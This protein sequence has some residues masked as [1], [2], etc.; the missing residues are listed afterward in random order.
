MT[1]TRQVKKKD[2]QPEC[3]RSYKHITVANSPYYK[4]TSFAAMRPIIETKDLK[5]EQ[6]T[7]S[8]SSP[9]VKDHVE[10]NNNH[11]GFYSKYKRMSSSTIIISQ[12]TCTFSKSALSTPSE[13]PSILSNLSIS[14]TELR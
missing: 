7:W 2:L 6:H 4:G 13:N 1:N 10:M 11:S 8:K 14:S 5:Q 9:T 3:M 12:A